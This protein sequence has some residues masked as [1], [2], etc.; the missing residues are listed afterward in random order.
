MYSPAQ[1]G[2]MIGKSVKTLQRWDVE[3]TLVAHRNPKNRRYYTHDQY[4]KYIGIKADSSKALTFVYSRVS[5]AAQ[6]PD[7]KNQVEA[8]EEF[9]S[10]NGYA[11]DEWISETGSGLNYK[12]KNFNKLFLDIEMG[13]V[14]LL[15]IAHKDRLVRFGFEWFEAFAQRHGCEI[16]IMNQ[17]SLSPAEEVTQ[18]LL[19][20]I[21]CFS[22]RLY[23]LRKYKDKVK[24]LVETKGEM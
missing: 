18:D 22:S 12:R 3:K 24:N 16:V 19:A 11:I 4:L 8:L 2:K 14:S 6:K 1:F 23:G 13:K 20:I 21:H 7:L 15:I 5:S 9:C 10:A 17:E